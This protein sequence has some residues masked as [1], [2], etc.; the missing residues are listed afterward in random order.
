M[1]DDPEE[2]DIFT[3][4]CK[5]ASSFFQLDLS[6]KRSEREEKRKKEDRDL[7]KELEEEKEKF[8]EIRKKYSSDNPKFKRSKQRYEL[9][10]RDHEKEKKALEEDEFKTSI[11]FAQI[12][13]EPFE[14]RYFAYLVGLIVLL[15]SF[16]AFLLTLFFVDIPML[17]KLLTLFPV[18]ILPLIAI[19]IV[20]NFPYYLA[21]RRRAKTVGRMPEAINYMVMAMSLTPNLGRAVEYAAESVE[22]PLS[23]ELR[24]IIWNVEMRKYSKIEDSLLAFADE[25]GKWSEEFKRSLYTLRNAANKETQE[26][27][28]RSLEKAND[29]AVRGAENRMRS[30]AE[31]LTIPAMTLFSLGSILP[32]LIAALLPVLAVGETTAE[33]IIIFLDVIIPVGFLTYAIHILGYRPAIRVSLSLPSYLTKK[34]TYMIWSISLSIAVGMI[35]VGFYLRPD[36]SYLISLVPLWGLTIA[37]TVYCFF[38][39]YLPYK[40]RNNIIEMERDFPNSL[41]HL[42][43]YISRGD[44][45]ERAFEKVAENIHSSSVNVLFRKISYSLHVTRKSLSDV[46]F[47]R[48][49]VLEKHPSQ[50]IRATTTTITRAIQ[51]DPKTAGDTL[52]RISGYL[53]QL[54]DIEEEMKSRLQ[55]ITGMMTVT[56]QFIAPLVMGITSVLYVILAGYF[57]DLDLGGPLSDLAGGFVGQEVPIGGFIFSLIVGIYLIMLVLVTVYFTVGIKSGEDWA[58][59]KMAI[60]K[61]L[62]VSILLYTVA[63]L[64]AEAFLSGIV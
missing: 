24:K 18:F 58:A 35:A 41:F 62:P 34:E 53:N 6:E 37:I 64:L 9:A 48:G 38:T 52:V 49:G 26:E 29:I 32:L 60:A 36:H 12:D 25:W 4:G 61:V 63:A 31:A 8:D 17:F 1:P 57:A 11:K 46:L 15:I 22:E 44:P 30:F 21:K 47:G 50:M 13:A 23:S 33:L 40:R 56:A 43:G 20:I 16:S 39:S 19:A 45:P 54:M 42:G 59:R 3:K 27:V 51:K 2:Q 10:L 55:E 5:F 14:V 7:D 28:N